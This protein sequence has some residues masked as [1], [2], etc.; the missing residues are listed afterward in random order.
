MKKVLFIT[1]L[2][3]IIGYNY[4]LLSVQSEETSQNSV[5]PCDYGHIKNKKIIKALDSLIG[6]DG[7]WARRVI[8]GKNSTNKPVKIL[9]KNL[10]TISPQFASMD[11]LGWQ[12]ENNNLIIFI[13]NAHK[14]APAE[15]IAALLSHESI[16]QDKQNS[17]AEETYGW[18]YEAEVWIQLK[19][20]YPVLKNISPGEYP[21]VDR[22]NLMEMLFRK[23]NFSSKLIEEKV[24]SNFSYK[25]LPET[26]P[27]FGM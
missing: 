17:F 11:A 22:E 26:S 1:L 19:N 21:L 5:M 15:A 7:E 8:S 23:G 27:G 6:T 20:K 14:D 18:T 2:S 9:F 25:S 13:N 3:L 10:S 16:H 12:D 4:N 24:R